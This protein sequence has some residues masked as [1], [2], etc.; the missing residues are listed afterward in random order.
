MNYLEARK[1]LEQVNIYGS[2]LGLDTIVHLLDRLDNP[3]NSLNVIHI[4][5]T[6]G[7]GSTAAF[8]ANILMC[9]GYSVGR[10]SSP[11][12]FNY[13]EIIRFNGNC[14][15][16]EQ[17]TYYINKIKAACDSMVAEGMAHPTPFEIETAM[18][19]LYLKDMFQLIFHLD[20]LFQVYNLPL[21]LLPLL[22]LSTL[23]L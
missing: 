11:A 15:S 8:V 22:R 4:A 12:V 1:Y 5:G 7:K 20:L 23:L 3:Q 9:A 14:I 16:E 19:F 13:R 10:Y 18:A 6:N 17:V 21:L 2:V